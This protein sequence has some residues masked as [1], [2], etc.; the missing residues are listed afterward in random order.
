MTQFDFEAHLKRQREWSGRTFGPGPR[1]AGVVDHIRKELA[2]IT[3]APSDISEWI[4]VVILALDGAWR[5]GASP[6]D[7]IAALVAKQAKNEARVWPDWR[8]MS[9]D[10]AIEHDRSKDGATPVP[11]PRSIA[12]DFDGTIYAD[13]FVRPE[14]VDGE[15]TAGAMDWL[16]EQ[17]AAG[18]IVI[19]HTCRLTPHNPD[20][21]TWNMH[22]DQSAVIAAIKVW[23]GRWLNADEVGALRWWT[24]AG[25]PSAQVYLD[26][27]GVRFEGVFPSFF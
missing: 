1:T 20:N 8:T 2:E 3:A 13:K 21:T 15:P 25:K 18:V 16:R 12:L 27:K 9:P 22:A 17:L 11:R 4:D 6:Q 10:K 14:L 19:I 23:L 7:I 5:A 26:D 24:H